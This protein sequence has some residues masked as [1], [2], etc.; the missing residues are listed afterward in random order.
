MSFKLL[1]TFVS[2]LARKTDFFLGGQEGAWEKVFG[3]KNI[4][5]VFYK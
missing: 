5:Y 3:I 1:D 2:F 4:N